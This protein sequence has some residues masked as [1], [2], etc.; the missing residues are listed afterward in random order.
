MWNN[1]NLHAIWQQGVFEVRL[2]EDMHLSAGGRLSVRKDGEGQD[3]ENSELGCSG[4]A[5]FAGW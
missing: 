3:A 4:M 5:I 1:G 2:S